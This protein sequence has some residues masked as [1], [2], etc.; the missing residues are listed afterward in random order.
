MS[1]EESKD[2]GVVNATDIQ[3]INA[4]NKEESAELVHGLQNHLPTYKYEVGETIKE[5]EFKK[6]CAGKASNGEDYILKMFDKT[7]LCDEEDRKDVYKECRLTQALA[8]PNT[9]RV[10]DMS[11]TTSHMIIAYEKCEKTLKKLIDEKDGIFRESE[12]MSMFAQICLGLDWLH[13]KKVMHKNLFDE[14]IY[15]TEDNMVKI[16]SLRNAKVMTMTLQVTGSL[17]IHD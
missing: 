7:Q 3:I 13:S 11:E 9:V 17:D 12:I 8:H 2:S 10:V 1:D 14:H 16:G 6:T 15:L 4:Q 5:D